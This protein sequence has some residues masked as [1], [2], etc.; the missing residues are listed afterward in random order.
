MKI[1]HISYSDN[2]GG[3]AIAALRIVKAQHK[4]GID[5]KMFVVLKNTDMSYILSVSKIRYIYI[6]LLT[7]ISIFFINKVNKS[8]NPI[9]H[10]INL[11]GSGLYKQI[12]KMDCDIIHLHWINGEMLSI[13]E[14][15]KINKP[16]VWTL[17][18]SWAFCGAEHYQNGMDDNSYAEGYLPKRYKGV[19]INRWVLKR[20]KQFWK[21]KHFYIVTPSNWETESAKKSSLFAQNITIPNCLDL[22]IF[23]PV[24]KYIA[25]NILNLC[26]D[27]RYILFGAVDV[28]KNPIKGG[29]LLKSALKLFIEKYETQ[30]VVLLIF[31]SSYY[32]S[33]LDIGLPIHFLGPI[34]SEYTMSLVYNASEVMLV[35]SKMDNL[36]QTAVEPAS[37]GIPVVCFNVGGLVDIVD[38]KST[39]YIANRFDVEDFAKGMNWILNEADYS[40]LSQKAREKALMNYN[41]KKCVDSYLNIYN[42]ILNNE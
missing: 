40:L 12:N 16:I 31:G 8:T 41:E 4:H 10:S 18:D 11:F 17:H 5:S 19:N 36:P 2:L 23:K 25:K 22:G 34:H 35:P 30:N 15:S 29:D 26:S 7:K 1:L 33:F 38:H 42:E 37:C 20:K 14:I 21:N 32:D 3:A 9:L 39:G 13:K 27:K 24:D 6:R 28:N